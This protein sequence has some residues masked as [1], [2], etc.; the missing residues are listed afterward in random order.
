MNNTIIIFC[1][2]LT[3]ILFILILITLIYLYIKNKYKKRIDNL[4][5][6]LSIERTSLSNITS[7]KLSFDDCNRI[8]DFIVDDIWKNKYFISYRL[9]DI[10]I[11]PSMDDEII[12]FVN[13][14]IESISNDV[15]N[16]ALKYYS[17][18]YLIKKITRTAQMLFIEY[19]NTY[20]PN[21]K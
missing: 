10:S 18:E 11:I 4:E 14:V 16:E 13:E 1:A 20:K 8:I 17:H 15:M 6:D 3:T 5:H 21:T 12:L 2:L 19:T 9:R 7:L